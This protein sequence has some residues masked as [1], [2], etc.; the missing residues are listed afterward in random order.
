MP[1]TAC[2]RALLLGSSRAPTHHTDVHIVLKFF[3]PAEAV[4]RSAAEYEFR[5]A[6]LCD[7]RQK[8]AE[9]GKETREAQAAQSTNSA[10][11]VQ[12]EEG[13]EAEAANTPSSS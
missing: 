5:A 6:S 3:G 11:H 12:E 9:Q 10:S 2:P 1:P 13:V 7:T 4:G 8:M